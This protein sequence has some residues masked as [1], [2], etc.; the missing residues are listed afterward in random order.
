MTV[1]FTLSILTVVARFLIR[2]LVQRQISA[3]DGFILLGTCFLI[4]AFTTAYFSIDN[5]YMVDAVRF[6]A[7]APEPPSD[8]IEREY[9]F[10]TMASVCLICSWMT[11]VSIKL[12]FLALFKTLIDLLP[13]LIMYWRVTLIFNLAVSVYGFVRNIIACP[14]FDR[15][16]IGESLVIRFE[17]GIICL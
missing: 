9:S 8:I 16:G 5:M 4:A 12:S 2:V 10:H 14:Y 11:V 3:D 1:L 15:H 17:C 7:V 6:G 13:R